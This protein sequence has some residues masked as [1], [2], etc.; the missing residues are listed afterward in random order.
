MS[1]ASNSRVS[2]S[3]PRARPLPAPRGM[4]GSR[5]RPRVRVVRGGGENSR[6]KASSRGSSRS[7]RPSWASRSIPGAGEEAADVEV[8]GGHVQVAVIALHPRG[9][10]SQPIS[11]PVKQAVGPDLQGQH[12]H[13]LPGPQVPAPGRISTAHP[14]PALQGASQWR[15]AAPAAPRD[16]RSKENHPPGVSAGPRR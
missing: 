12:R 16:R 14:A 4:R 7:R 1:G 6:A 15:G 10:R 5:V 13:L 3:Q 11:Q 9:Q 8:V 2:P